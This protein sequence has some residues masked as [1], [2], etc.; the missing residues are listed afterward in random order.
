MPLENVGNPSEKSPL[1]ERPAFDNHRAMWGRNA[2][3]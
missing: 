3:Q 2:A 1:R